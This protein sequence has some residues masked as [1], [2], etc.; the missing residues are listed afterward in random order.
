MKAFILV[1][2]GIAFVAST[3][4]AATNDLGF[5]AG[6][7]VEE[8]LAQPEGHVEFVE[9]VEEEM[10]ERKSKIFY[11]VDTFFLVSS[12]SDFPGLHAYMKCSQ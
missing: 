2:L 1:L 11:I 3:L 6:P 8:V 10:A 12:E 4:E 9:A 5:E 7:A